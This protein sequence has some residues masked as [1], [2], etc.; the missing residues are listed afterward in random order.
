VAGS[1]SWLEVGAF[2]IQPSEFAK[3]AACLVLGKYLSSIDIRITE[4]RTKLIAAL[5]IGLPMIL[6]LLQNDTGSA[7][8]F[9]SFIFVLYFTKIH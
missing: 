5:L 8:V 9:C 7:L 2:R 4:N 3:F 6:V 1:R